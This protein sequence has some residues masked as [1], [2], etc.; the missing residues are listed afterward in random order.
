MDFIKQ[1]KIIV[2]VILVIVTG[3]V[4]LVVYNM[5]GSGSGTKSP[6]L[7]NE[8]QEVVEVAPSDIGLKLAPRD[9]GKAI[10]IEATKIDGIESLE[11]ELTY[12]AEVTEG[13]QTHVIPR[14]AIG[15][16]KIEGD[17]AKA[18]VDL[19]TCSSGICKYDNVVS[20]VK[21]LIKINYENSEIGAAEDEIDIEG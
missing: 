7:N 6:F 5:L 3:L 17:S 9:D 15:E 18:E 1:N 14:G 21:V 8:Q 13:G 12:D 11:Y 19:G 4:G 10:I 2:G 20:S 16:L